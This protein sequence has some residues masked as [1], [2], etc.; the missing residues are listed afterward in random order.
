MDLV[1]KVEMGGHLGQSDH[2]VIE[3]KISVERRKSASKTSTLDMR[4]A[5]FRLLREL[6]L[7]LQMDPYKFMGPDRIHP[8]ILKKLADVITK[9]LDF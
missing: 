8:R 1:S 4:R 7:L 9:T 6:D 5:D 3:F 2:E